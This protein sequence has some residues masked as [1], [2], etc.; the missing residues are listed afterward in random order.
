MIALR[1]LGKSIVSLG[2]RLHRA[3]ASDR[4][5]R[6]WWRRIEWPTVLLAIT[7]YGG[8]LAITWSYD[9][10]PWWVHL[11]IGG[12]FLGW[13]GSLQHETI[14]GHPTP[15]RRMNDAVGGLP[16][17]LW[18]PYGLYRASHMAHH[19]AD[20][21][22]PVDDPESYY[23][24]PRTWRKLG[25][26]GRGLYWIHNT[27]V[28][29]MLLG[30]PIALLKFVWAECGRLMR[31]DSSHLRHWGPHLIGVSLVLSWVVGICNMPLWF[32]VLAYVY[33]GAALTALR[34]YAEHRP[35]AEP[36]H[37]TAIVE[38]KLLGILY[39]H[40]NLHVLHHDAPQIPWYEYPAVYRRRRREMIEANG[41]YFFANYWQLFRRYGL[42]PKDHPV[43]V[44]PAYPHQMPQTPRRGV[45]MDVAMPAHVH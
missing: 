25:S 27:A 16:L 1:D 20:L 42:W 7:I 9:A 30:P 17:G 26:I 28:G 29:R 43:L 12:W 10:V 15:W 11:L 31:G 19:A 8:W 2:G 33:P 37:R 13:H 18:L 39:L 40:N 44:A 38:S 14:H 41:G 32:Y 6:R 21:T 45:A 24:L 22:D 34:S 3:G 5:A 23:V 35:D 36:A 4:N